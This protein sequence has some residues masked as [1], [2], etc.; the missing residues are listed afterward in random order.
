MMRRRRSTRLFWKN[1][2]VTDTHRTIVFF[3]S[4]AVLSTGLSRSAN[5]EDWPQWL[6]TSRQP[7]W[8]ETGI[9]DSF[10][11]DGPPLRW[12]TKIGS[13]YSGP[14]VANGKVFVMDRVAASSDLNSGKLLHEGD[15]PKNQNFVRRKLPGEERVVCLRESDGEILWTHKY[16]CPYTSTA[17]YAIGPRCT[18]TVDGEFVYTLGAEGDLRCLN[19]EDGSEVWKCDFKKQYEL[20]IPEW[21]IAAHPL[22]DGNRLICVV[23]GPGAIVVAFDKRNGKELW[24]ALSA[25]QPGYCPPMIHTIAGKRHLVIWDSDNVSGLNPET[26][27]VYWSIPFPATFAM[28]IGAPQVE[29]N[30]LFLMAYN[31]KSA[32]IKIDDDGLSADIVWQGNSKRGI[33]GVLNTSILLDGYIYACGNGGRYVC[34][35][36]ED[37]ER[38]WSTFEPT[39]G[40]RPGAWA[41]AFSIRQANR[42]FHANDNGEL[43]IAK[44]SPDG[45]EEISRS[46]LIEPTHK[47]SG[48]T[49]VWSHPAFANRS[50]YL[51]NDEEIRC[52]DLSKDASNEASRLRN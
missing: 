27:E 38:V 25:K 49:L 8:N 35:K 1:P 50:I 47:V 28:S 36:L 14:A 7:V 40:N 19:V 37:G 21:G 15:R 6:G 9:V 20:E 45:Y 18:P 22:V 48:R 2:V 44:M 23:G 34:A 46:K 51:R 5:A 33:D 52:Y 12:S 30:Q 26:G 3:I 13:G 42:F 10:P 32:M 16:P 41:N 24:R 4:A 31:R 39:T 17:I 29:G 43:I 11:K